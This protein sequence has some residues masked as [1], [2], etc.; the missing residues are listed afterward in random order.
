MSA[1]LAGN[2]I[3]VATMGPASVNEATGTT[4][5]VVFYGVNVQD[6]TVLKWANDQGQQGVM[7]VRG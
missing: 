7:E 6:T 5:C 2:T 1:C 3:S 4:S